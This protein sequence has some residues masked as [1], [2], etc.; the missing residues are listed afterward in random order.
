MD[1]SGTEGRRRQPS[2]QRT[3]RRDDTY[4]HYRRLREMKVRNYHLAR[5]EFGMRK[6]FRAVLCFK[7]SE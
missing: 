6:A 2:L 5:A 1:E 4:V 3:V 7:L